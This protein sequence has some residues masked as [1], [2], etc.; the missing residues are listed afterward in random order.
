MAPYFVDT[1]SFAADNAHLLGYETALVYG[2]LSLQGEF[3]QSF[4]N[5][6]EG[7]GDVYFQ[8]AYAS[9]SYFLTGE[10]R[11]YKKSKGSFSRVKPRKNFS[12][13]RGGLGAW[14]IASRYSYL[15]LKDGDI[16]GGI[17]SDVT[18]GINW[19]LNPNMRIMGNYVHANRNGV[20]SADIFQTRLQVDF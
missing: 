1:G 6:S 7:Q 20:G 8:G 11:N 10:H 17:M 16:L 4:V 5:R 19:Y 13:K 14:E 18:L 9:M 15:D 2:P 3:T 12:F